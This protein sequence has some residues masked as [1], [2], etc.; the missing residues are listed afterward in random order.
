MPDNFGENDFYEFGIN[1]E[2]W[3]LEYFFLNSNI[4]WKIGF[5]KEKSSTDD[6]PCTNSHSDYKNIIIHWRM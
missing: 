5:E 1:F 6:S 3:H 4:S 2:K